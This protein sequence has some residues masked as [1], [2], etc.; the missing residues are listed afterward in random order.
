MTKRFET[1]LL[2]EA[3][4]FIQNQNQKTRNKIF[5]ILEERSN[6]PTPNSLKN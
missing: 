3:F 5:Q 4:E 1:K 2:A 6:M